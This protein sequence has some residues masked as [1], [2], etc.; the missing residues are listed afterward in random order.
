MQPI[1]QNGQPQPTREEFIKGL[2]VLEPKD[3]FK[4]GKDGVDSLVEGVKKGYN[5]LKSSYGSAGGN[6]VIKAHVYPFYEVTNDGKKILDS[7]RLADPY[8]MI[9]LNGM[10]E[11]ANK[12]DKESGDGRK[13]ASLLYGAILME[14]QK[15]KEDPMD[16]K[17]SLEECIPVVLSEIDKQTEVITVDEVGKIASIASESPELGAMFQE[18]YKK[19]GSDGII[20]FDN[21]NI[22]ET[23]YEITEGVKLLNCGFMYP[24]MANADKGRKAEIKNPTILI[25][26]QKI[27]TMGQI[28][29]IIKSLIRNGVLELVIFCDNIDVSVSEALAYAAMAPEGI[30]VDGQ[31]INF[32]TL[33]IKAPV[34]WK[35][36]LFE[37]FAKITGATIVDPAQGTTLKNFQTKYFG[38]C[39]RLITSKTETI[40]LGTQDITDY[41]TALAEVGTDDAKL[42]AS[43]LKT[44][45]AVIKLGANSDAELS[46][47]RGKALDGRNSSYL[48]MQGGVVEGG[49]YALYAVSEKL[50]DTI[51]GQILAKSLKYPINQIRENLGKKGA[52]KPF[53]D[54][55]ID[56]SIVVKNSFINAVSV[57]ASVLTT[58]I[59]VE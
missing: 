5:A 16:I 24:Y 3:N 7:V 10:K 11:V 22:P 9:G 21:S 28:D 58:T 26:K 14:G 30:T 48:A 50:P 6:A 52:I 12:S 49:G 2:F 36:W 37:D 59:V 45:T 39:E 32:R 56:A 42:R 15:S 57:A 53:G 43:R 18:I 25:S 4:I 55:V 13:T 29:H 8:E 40:V 1:D 54:D 27:A 35:D 38:T 20:E 31:K 46:H 23:S 41:V 33:V 44:K 17:R 34:L 51:G 47:L 19:I